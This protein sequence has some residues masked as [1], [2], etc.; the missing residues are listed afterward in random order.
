MSVLLLILIFVFIIFSFLFFLVNILVLYQN[1]KPAGILIWIYDTPDEFE[2]NRHLYSIGL[3]ST[4]YSF[5]S[6]KLY[7]IIIFFL[8]LVDL[9]WNIGEKFFFKVTAC[10]T[11]R[12]VFDWENIFF[13]FLVYE[14][15]F[16][17]VEENILMR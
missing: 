1:I 13:F 7:I 14:T 15:G 8:V 10:T 3:L 11:N 16:L 4:E 6:F 9:L 12:A 5:S 2:K 17:C